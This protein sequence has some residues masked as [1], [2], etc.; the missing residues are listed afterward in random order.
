MLNFYKHYVTTY[1]NGKEICTKLCG[2]MITDTPSENFTE[3]L[4]WENLADKYADHGLCYPF[5]I[6]V[7]K[8]GRRVSF[9]N[10]FGDK[11]TKDIKE[12]KE[13]LNLTVKHEFV[14]YNPSINRILEWP[15]GDTAIKY[16]IERG[17]SITGK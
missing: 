2:K 10:D 12:W 11:F 8:R 4:T 6:W 14:Q 3:E 5:N 15:D 17:I 16:L 7:F 9:F 1:K 13:P